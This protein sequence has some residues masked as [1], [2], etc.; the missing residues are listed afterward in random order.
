MVKISSVLAK[1]IG[2]YYNINF[3]IISEEEWK[4]AL[5]VELEH[6]S[7]YGKLTN[8]TNDNIHLTAKIAMAH[9]I[10]APDYYKR[11]YKM[12]KSMDKYWNNKYKPSIFLS[13]K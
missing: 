3:N 2:N 9:L 10:E 8:I 13:T 11:L 4:Y 6:G 5:N 7:K 12:E 1:K